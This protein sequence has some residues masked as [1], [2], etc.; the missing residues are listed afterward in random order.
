MTKPRSKRKPPAKSA[1][2]EQLT[3]RCADC[4][5]FHRKRYDD[6]TCRRYPQPLLKL[7]SDTCGEFRPCPPTGGDEQIT[8]VC[9][10]SP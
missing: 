5:F 1:T 6:G 9:A 4:R 10:E 8:E 7:G 3:E 2:P